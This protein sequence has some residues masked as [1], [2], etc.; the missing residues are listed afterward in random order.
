MVAAKADFPGRK[1]NW[2]HRNDGQCTRQERKRERRGG[3]IENRDGTVTRKERIRK[4]RRYDMYVRGGLAKIKGPHQNSAGAPCRVSAS[5]SFPGLSIW[6][7]SPAR[8]PGA[9]R[10]NAFHPGKTNLDKSAGAHWQDK[11]S[12]NSSQVLGHSRIYLEFR[13]RRREQRGSE[14][15][16]QNKEYVHLE[17][18]GAGRL[19]TVLAVAG[20]WDYG[21]RTKRRGREMKRP[22]L[23]RDMRRN[24]AERSGRA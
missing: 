5:A 24:L 6:V 9:R 11:L 3:D 18:V 21:D 7:S 2:C 10:E 16:I 15:P 20:E 8:V 23:L 12:L 13:D 1:L 22:L 14:I 4:R 17:R 19:E